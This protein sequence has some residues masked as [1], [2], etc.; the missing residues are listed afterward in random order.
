M[1]TLATAAHRIDDVIV[2]IETVAKQTNLLALNATIEAARAG[3][4]GKGF[5]VVAGEVK[6]LANRTAEATGEITREIAHMQ[7]ATAAVVAAIQDIIAMVGSLD[8]LAKST[9]TEMRTQKEG[10]S[11]VSTMLVDAVSTADTAVSQVSGI[12]MAASDTERKAGAVLDAADRMRTEACAL[13]REV[14]AFLTA[15]RST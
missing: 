2:V 3:E 15:V 13:R 1:N 8:G 10:L 6:H 12:A 14:D 7:Q 9:A 11:H 4:A 5:A